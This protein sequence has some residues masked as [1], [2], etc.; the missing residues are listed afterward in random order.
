MNVAELVVRHADTRPDHCALAFGGQRITYADYRVRAGRLAAALLAR[1]VRQGD[2]VL[3]Y[4]RNNAEYFLTYTA[5][6]WIGA[7]FAP[8]HHGFKVNEMAYVAGNAAARLAFVEEAMLPAYA[9]LSA[10]LSDLPRDVVLVGPSATRDVQGIDLLTTSFEDALGV[11]LELPPIQDLEP[12]TPVLICYTSGSTSS[13]KPV[14]RSHG[15]E[16]WNAETYHR[17]WDLRPDDHALMA[18]PLSWVY[19]LSTMGQALLAAGSTIEILTHFNP[20]AVLAAIEAHQITVFGGTNTMYV[21]LLDVYDRT[22]GDLSSLRNCYIGGEP[23]SDGVVERF[24]SLIGSRLWQGYAATEAAPVILTD[25]LQDA[26]APRRTVGRL[27][28]GAEIRLV[29]EDGR[30]VPPGQPGEAQFRCPGSMLGYFREDALT[31][32]RVTPDGWFRTGDLVTERDGYYFVV[33]RKID[34]II[35]GGSNIAPAEVESALTSVPGIVDAVVIGLPDTEYGEQVAA[36]ISTNGYAPDDK[37]LAQAVARRLAAF[38]IPTT[39]VRDL[40]LPD[41]KNGKRDRKAVREAVLA[42][43]SKSPSPAAQ[44]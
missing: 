20:V 28:P 18:L 2:R 32:E 39:F 23:S 40:R 4:S 29:D 27:V 17:Y 41:G 19:G 44:A 6:A 30:P 43:L 14:L 16:A 22:G 31:K 11:G 25:P 9:E 36:V 8:V 12:A 7:V 3:F 33:G 15:G 38:K 13:P 37:D 1:G 42:H 21:K 34:M 10:Q 5:C 26:E 35:R 24:E